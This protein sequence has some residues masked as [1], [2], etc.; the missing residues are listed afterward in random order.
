MMLTK[1]YALFLAAGVLGT[2]IA[3]VV[4]GEKWQ[5]VERSA[6]SGEKRPL[7]LKLLGTFLLAFY[8]VTL[9]SFIIS[10]DK[11][12]AGWIL[13]VFFPVAWGI[14]GAL[15]IFN[16]EGREKVISIEG[17]DNWRKIALA[18]L[19]V[20]IILVVLAVFV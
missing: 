11:S 15:V 14:K 13:L 8:A 7:W 10:P 1:I 20:V 12:I 18:R 6:Y 2:S 4:M 17:A 16:K 9:Y 5:A 3:M 19:P